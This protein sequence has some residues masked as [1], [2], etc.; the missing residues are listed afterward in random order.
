MPNLVH[1]DDLLSTTETAALLGVDVST[2][3]RWVNA[4]KLT[5]AR[6]M[7]GLR[8]VYLFRRQDVEALAGAA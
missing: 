6:K 8:G 2:I 4:G 1:P 7:P 5:P 3:S